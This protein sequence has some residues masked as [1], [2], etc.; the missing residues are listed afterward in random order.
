VAV[1]GIVYFA[2]MTA[3][4][5]LFALAGGAGW[6]SL[7]LGAL[8][9][10]M[11]LVNLKDAVWLAKGPSLVIPDAAKPALYRRMRAVANAAS[12]PAAL[13]GVL[14]LAALANLVELGCTVGLPAMYTRVLTLRGDLAPWQRIAWVALYNVFYV[15]PLAVVVVAWALAVRRLVVSERSARILKG[16]SGLLLVISG[17]ALVVIGLG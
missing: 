15:I 10:L 12:W 2:F 9:L 16:C 7:A 14:L 6:V 4:S 13:G 3:W 11:G 1:S 17:A 5:G 8:L